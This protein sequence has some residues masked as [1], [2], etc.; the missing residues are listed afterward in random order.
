M[1]FQPHFKNYSRAW[2]GSVNDHYPKYKKWI[3]DEKI[4]GSYSSACI[5]DA[6]APLFYWDAQGAGHM[7]LLGI[8]DGPRE[9]ECGGF[10]VDMSLSMIALVGWIAEFIDSVDTPMLP[11]QANQRKWEDFDAN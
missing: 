5:A 10:N 1:H 6:G 8:N 9:E 4:W 3:Q 11:N 7:F 2:M